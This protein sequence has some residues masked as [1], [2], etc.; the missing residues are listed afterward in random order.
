MPARQSKSCRNAKCVTYCH[1]GFIRLIDHFALGVWNSDH[2]FV[3]VGSISYPEVSYYI[4]WCYYSTACQFECTRKSTLSFQ[5]FRNPRNTQTRHFQH[6]SPF[7]TS[8]WFSVGSH[9]SFF[10]RKKIAPYLYSS[11][12]LKSK[13]KQAMQDVLPWWKFILHYW[14]ILHYP[15]RDSMCMKGQQVAPQAKQAHTA[16]PFYASRQGK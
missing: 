15:I 2:T 8:C 11:I 16:T 7:Y 5:I 1:T 14:W 6:D 10:F 9:W 12:N 3:T 4:L 13:R